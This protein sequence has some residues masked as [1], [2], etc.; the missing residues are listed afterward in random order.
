MSRIITDPK[1]KWLYRYRGISERLDRMKERLEVLEN[2]MEGV[3]SPRLT[4]MPRGGTPVTMEELI[5]D[6]LE[7]EER[8][9]NLEETRKQIRREILAAIDTL[10]DDKLSEI[11]ELRFIECLDYDD[12]ADQ[13]VY[14]RR[15][16]ERLYAK[17]IEEIKISDL[18][19]S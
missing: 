8:I 13:L 15:H 1:K 18:E 2:R 9:A 14:T 11:L 16:V 4:G 17:A 5:S 12:I 7:I 3:R 6:K 10:T 19:E